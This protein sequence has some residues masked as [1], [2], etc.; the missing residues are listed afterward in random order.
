MRTL[1]VWLALLLIAGGVLRPAPAAAATLEVTASQDTSIFF[2]TPAALSLAD[3]SGDNLWLAVTAE[4]L[5]RRL[6]LRFDVSAIPPGATV[7]A[8]TLTLY[9][10]RSRDNHDVA[11]HRLLA[12]WG[13]GASNAGGAG[14][15]APAMAGDATWAHR[16]HP[17]TAWA[18][19]GGDFDPAPSAVVP[20]GPPDVFYSWAATLPPG[21][22]P[23]PKLVSDVQAWVDTPASNHGWI[24]IGKETDSQNAKR[25]QSRNNSLAQNRPRLTVV[26]DLPPASGD[27]EVPLPA[28][29]LALLALILLR[30]GMA[31]TDHG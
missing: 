20:V 26:Y 6:L 15:G 10:S 25:F 22:T 2:G 27:G 28:W 12:S 4:G 14:T 30:A 17:A 29:S 18:T 31:R 1:P 5:G 8:V 24:L 3:G 19:P 16:F 23:M 9:Q 7:R 21:G 13:E 11:V